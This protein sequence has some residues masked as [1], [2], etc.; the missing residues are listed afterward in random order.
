MHISTSAYHPIFLIGYSGVGKTYWGKLWS[1]LSGL[2][3][4]DLDDMVE[5][6]NEKTISEI[7]ASDGEEHFRNL[8]TAALRTFVNSKNVIVAT[9]GGT[10]CFNNNIS[11]MNKNGLFTIIGCKYFKKTGRRKRKETI[12]KRSQRRGTAFL[13]LRKNK[14]ERNILQTGNDHFKH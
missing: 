3:F 5:E 14:R 11:W 6:Q 2:T 9:G 8:E 10:P 13:H 4:Y 12:D 7:F 1:E